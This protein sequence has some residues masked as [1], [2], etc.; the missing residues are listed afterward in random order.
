DSEPEIFWTGK[1]A[2]E[3][4]E[5]IPMLSGAGKLLPAAK[6]LNGPSGVALDNQFLKPLGLDRKDAWLC[7]LVPHSCLNSGQKTA[8][9]LKYNP[10]KAELHLPDCTTPNVPET[11]ADSSRSNEILDELKTA[12]PAVIITLGDQ[13]LKWFTSKFG[14]KLRLEDYGKPKENV[15]GL[16]HDIVIDGRA[17]KLLPLVHP[18]QAA[19]LGAHSKDWA[20]CHDKWEKSVAPGLLLG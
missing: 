2:K 9:D 19:S 1:G 6:N 4:I 18:R 14:S 15:Y 17:I 11:L 5:K 7:D 13:P 3:I 8:I 12:D 16:L 20:E 10:K